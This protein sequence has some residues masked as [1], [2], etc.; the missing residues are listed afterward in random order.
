MKK[1][2]VLLLFITIQKSLTQ[3]FYIYTDSLA[4][5]NWHANH[6]WN[7]Q[8]DLKNQSQK[9][10][11]SNSI[12]I[13]FQ[14]AYSGF[15]LFLANLNTSGYD[16]LVFWVNGGNSGGHSFWIKVSTDGKNFLEGKSS[17]D[18]VQIEA[19]KW[20]EV[21]IPLTH[22]LDSNFYIVSILFQEN[23]GQS[24]PEFFIDDIYLTSISGNPKI[25]E[26]N[27]S[28]YNF[29]PG[30]KISITAR[31]NDE[32]GLNDLKSVE[33]DCSSL[34]SG[35]KFQL[36]DDG[37][38]NDYL[39]NDGIFGNEITI[40]SNTSNGEK[41]INIIVEDKSGKRASQEIWV[42]V[43]ISDS[44]QIPLGLPR[45][46][47]I[48]TGTTTSNLSWQTNN[49]NDCWDLG[50][51]YIT[52]GWWNWYGEFVKRFC[53]DAHRRGYI[54]VIPVYMF[55]TAPNEF[56]CTGNEY[57]KIY[58]A[59][60][61]SS[62]MN[63][64]W[65]RFIQMC[66]EANRSLASKVIFHIEPDMLGYL[67]QRAIRENKEPSQI[68]AF[69]NDTRYPN[70]LSGMH[71]RMI[72]IVREHCPQKGMIAFHASLWGNIISLKENEEKI[73]DIESLARNTADFL[74]KLSPDFDLIFMDWSDRDAG[75]DEIWWDKKNTS[76]P[77]FSRVLMFTNYL[78][79]FTKKKIVLWQI[80]IGNEMLPNI[81]NQYAD[82]RLDYIF[83][84]PFDIAKSGIISLLFG[85][86][87]PNMTTQFTDGGHLKSRA[88]QY[89][90]NGKIDLI[91]LTR[92][93]TNITSSNQELLFD[94]N[95]PNPFSSYTYLRFYL[96]EFYDEAVNE[97]VTYGNVEIKIFNVLG[98]EVGKLLNETK[99]AGQYEIKFTPSKF[100]LSGGIYFLKLN[101]GKFSRTI[102][103]VYLK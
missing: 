58:C 30:D 87:I 68:P 40:P 65:N 45:Y 69:I 17:T 99:T 101:Y 3:P 86:G 12:S 82:N 5:K 52:W 6:S 85:A 9:F 88:L 48:G 15:V 74:M 25:L 103:I 23:K 61:N 89:C 92:K 70:N 2:L 46:L 31:I 43:L 38:H 13:K 20:K 19:N 80:P 66:D 18:Y 67:Q 54:P 29:Y 21:K 84:H 53:D 36:F 32:D 51:Q 33:V 47:S 16:S 91:N 49:G 34:L 73:L 8:F 24:Q 62:L 97:K 98:Q 14:N 26:T 50:Y 42:G 75:Y 77:N 72:D 83:D 37:A 93:D 90:Q 95:F 79:I 35:L 76:L 56:G 59:I 94:Q 7:T 22:I 41:I 44:I 102:K 96:P 78:S 60:N 1:I 81:V 57:D 55:Q 63:E 11:G 39:E 10:S 27:L 28:S 4:K 71:Q 100:N 64:F